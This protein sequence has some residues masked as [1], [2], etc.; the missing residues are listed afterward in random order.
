MNC[1]PA[2]R[3][4]HPKGGEGGKFLAFR[5]RG[6]DRQ[7]ARR[8]PV[9]LPLGLAAKI[10]GALKDQKFLEHARLVDRR[11][12]AQAR[13]AGI[14]RQ[15]NAQ[16]RRAEIEHRLVIAQRRRPAI[17]DDG[18]AHRLAVDI[19]VMKQLDAVGLFRAVEDRLVGAELDVAVLIVGEI[20]Q[21]LRHGLA[22]PL[23]RRKRR[24]SW[25]SPSAY[26][27]R[28]ASPPRAGLRPPPAIRRGQAHAPGR[29]ARRPSENRVYSLTRF[30]HLKP[31]W[32]KAGGM[33]CQKG[34]AQG[35]SCGGMLPLVSV[36]QV[37]FDQVAGVIALGG[38]IADIL[39]RDA[40]LCAMA[41]HD[42]EAGLLQRVHLERIV[43][44]QLDPA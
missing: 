35:S 2:G 21:G 3:R 22:W 31:C 4:L 13:E 27:R 9:S 32:L 29:R 6:V 37:F 24:G 11:V 34:Q 15:R 28:T 14:V 20:G 1:S 5:L 40:R 25:P 10:A 18:D 44:Q 12:D 33:S 17:F 36:F 43:G 7:A 26:P 38:E 30:P 16:L 8:K 19:A 39:Q 42:V 41:G 23:D